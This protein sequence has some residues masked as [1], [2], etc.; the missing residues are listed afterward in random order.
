MDDDLTFGTS[1]WGTNEVVD[2]ILPSVQ[3]TSHLRLSSSEVQYGD[4]HFSEPA[5]SHPDVI[6]DDFA[7][8]GDFGEAE[9]VDSTGFEPDIGFGEEVR[10]AGPSSQVEWHPLSLDPLPLRLELEERVNEILHPIWSYGNPSNIFTEEPI[11]EAEG[12]SQILVTQARY[13]IPSHIIL[14]HLPSDAVVTCTRCS[15]NYHLRRSRQ[16]G[17]GHEYV[18][19]TS[20]IS[21]SLST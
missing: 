12:V 9:I 17:R 21:E 7:D 2:I 8:F 13:A 11:R 4:D 15:F 16:T 14:P 5:E 3:T 1:V 19:T 20:S 10:I 6:D 18:A